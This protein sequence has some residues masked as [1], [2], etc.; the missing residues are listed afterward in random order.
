MR[1]T[2]SCQHYGSND[3]TRQGCQDV[4]ISIG[5]VLE[6]GANGRPDWPYC[7][8]AKR[9]TSIAMTKADG[10]SWSDLQWRR[11]LETF[12]EEDDSVIAQGANGEVDGIW[13]VARLLCWERH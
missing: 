1:A 13:C 7:N 2:R 12:G 5:M 4:S 11:R 3:F 9:L 8:A 6:P 10:S